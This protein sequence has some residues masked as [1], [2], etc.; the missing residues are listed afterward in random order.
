MPSM[1]RTLS[2]PAKGA[3]SP[4]T[5][6]TSH[7]RK[8]GRPRVAGGL[9]TVTALAPLVGL[10]V[11]T[12]LLL[13]VPD[14][15]H[16]AVARPHG[17]ARPVAA[18]DGRGL[19]LAEDTAPTS[20]MPFCRNSSFLIS[21]GLVET[22]M[23]T[24]A[25][26]PGLGKAYVP[27]IS[28]VVAIID[29]ANHART[30]SVD[31]S[32]HQDF[33]SAVLLESL[34]RLY[35][36]SG[37][38]GE[39]V[40]IQVD[41]PVPSVVASTSL[42]TALTPVPAK[43]FFF[44]A[45]LDP[46]T[47]TAYYGEVTGYVA[48]VHLPTLTVTRTA[49]L[50]GQP[51]LRSAALDASASYLFIGS[52]N[53]GSGA[54]V[55]ILHTANLTLAAPTL[56]FPSHSFVA[57]AANAVDNVVY[58]ASSYASSSVVIIDAAPPFAT[59]ILALPADDAPLL[60]A[61]YIPSAQTLLLG[62][63][64]AFGPGTSRV[65]ALAAG[66]GVA[67]TRTGAATMD[68][69]EVSLVAAVHDAAADAVYLPCRG[70]SRMLVLSLTPPNC[71]AIAE[72]GS[73]NSACGCGWCASSESCHT[74]DPNGPLDGATCPAAAWDYYD[75]ANCVATSSSCSHCATNPL[76]GWCAATQQCVRGSAS[77]PVVASYCPAPIDWDYGSCPACHT[78]GPSCSACVAD[79][80]CGWCPATAT[81]ERG[82]APDSYTSTCPSWSFAACRGPSC[83][84]AASCGACASADPHCG[85]CAS[86]T[87]CIEGNATTPYPIAASP[88][89]CPG[90]P[91]AWTGAVCSACSLH[92]NCSACGAD[93]LCGWCASSQS[94]VPGAASGPHA[95]PTCDAADWSYDTSACVDCAA[96]ASCSACTALTG[97]GWC[98]Q[99]A[100]CERGSDTTSYTSTC[101][102]ASGWARDSC[103]VCATASGSSCASC[104]SLAGCGWCAST[105]TCLA[106]DAAGAWPGQATCPVTHWDFAGAG[107]AGCREC[108]SRSGCATCQADRRCGFCYAD[109]L[110]KPSD[111]ATGSLIGSQS[112]GT[113]EAVFF[114]T[115]A[116]CPDLCTGPQTCAACAASDP[117]CGWCASS[118][119]CMPSYL[120]NSTC[121][122][123]DGACDRCTRH[124]A[125]CAACIAD[126]GC[127]LCDY[128][129]A[130][131]TCVPGSPT[132]PYDIASCP[133]GSLDGLP[134]WLHGT[135]SGDGLR[136]LCDIS[137]AA[138]AAGTQPS[139]AMCL[140]QAGCGWCP[141][142][143]TCHT[144]A[145]STCSRDV[146]TSACPG[147]SYYYV[148]ALA[149][150]L[151]L[152]LIAGCVFAWLY[153]RDVRPLEE[154]LYD[155][156]KAYD[157]ANVAA[158][159]PGGVDAARTHG[160]APPAPAKAGKSTAAAAA[161]NDSQ[162]DD[163]FE[164]VGIDRS[165]GDPDSSADAER[166]ERGLSVSAKRRKQ[167]Q[168]KVA[169]AVADASEHRD[170]SAS[171]ADLT[172]ASGPPPYARDVHLRPLPYAAFD[173]TAVPAP[174]EPKAVLLDDLANVLR[175]EE[176][177]L[178]SALARVVSVSEDGEE[179]A[180][181]LLTVL[182]AEGDAIAFVDAVVA[183]EVAVTEARQSNTLLRA[184]TMA[185]KV[186]KAFCGIEALEYVFAV[187]RPYLLH[188]LSQK[189]PHPLAPRTASDDATALLD[190][191][192]AVF[193]SVLE[194]EAG[195]PAPLRAVLTLLYD[196][197]SHSQ[198][199]HLSTRAVSS[200]LFLRLLS[201]ALCSPLA[202]GLIDIEADGL[203]PLSGDAQRNLVDVSKVLQA[204]A[205]QA[206]FGT[207]N[208]HLAGTNPW[209][210]AAIR[211]LEAFVARLCLDE[212]HADDRALLELDP[213]YGTPVVE[214]A[215]SA[216]EVEGALSALVRL[217]GK[218]E[219]ELRS[220]L[221]EAALR[222]GT[223]RRCK[224][225]G[226]SARGE[227]PFDHVQ[228]NI[229]EIFTHGA[230]P[231]AVAGIMAKDTYAVTSALVEVVKPDEGDD[232]AGALV[233]LALGHDGRDGGMRLVK[234]LAAREL[235][236]ATEPN[237]VLRG[238]HVAAKVAGLYAGIVGRAWRDAVVGPSLAVLDTLASVEDL[239]DA[240]GDLLERAFN[241]IDALPLELRSI[242][243][244]LNAV[245]GARFPKRATP[246][247][248]TVAKRMASVIVH[249][250]NDMRFGVGTPDDVVLNEFVARNVAVMQGFLMEASRISEA[251]ALAAAE[252]AADAAG[253]AWFDDAQISSAA[254]YIASRLHYYVDNA[255][256]CYV[257]HFY[258]FYDADDV[259][260]APDASPA[261]ASAAALAPA[262][263]DVETGSEWAV[264]AE[265]SRILR[266]WRLQA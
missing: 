238:F 75:C 158:G 37:T 229:V 114:E 162:D 66:P 127:G 87:S 202:Y 204:V 99:T 245:V 249:M 6:G 103:P 101:T 23:R 51:K 47:A 233:L 188:A 13:L 159:L 216:E 155:P 68:T 148:L 224:S 262:T 92:T 244:H 69:D 31:T 96:A 45:V 203:P 226:T 125:D 118:S 54:V 250:V 161:A 196:H 129:S 258:H 232:V 12:L 141:S 208:A 2:P 105:A 67:L 109:G 230:E 4:P 248:R 212:P 180:N 46:A 237:A 70:S 108:A 79:P 14:N 181:A 166:D 214:K 246:N 261:R 182:A 145:L 123:W 190:A 211:E 194:S 241:G 174:S 163:E 74:G 120:S 26:D 32:P 55:A 1:G 198:F 38:S 213:A 149:L 94:C 126:D 228:R 177:V 220:L 256:F 9:H 86:S 16:A 19:L 178:A 173:S 191:V 260:Y 59:S 137:S 187:L 243:D 78:L 90:D 263:D 193:A 11:I 185:S 219:T 136:D 151:L 60:S 165:D 29:T 231:H 179:A 183:D 15:T 175:H 134:V 44:A 3:S 34:H 206:L 22:D 265:L 25:L 95:A 172:L 200:V 8:T 223:S 72:C 107:G 176:H 121:K 146:V 133:V 84:A 199:A 21:P 61:V 132:G 122:V 257:F 48:S 205:N 10:V 24:L 80:K 82:A 63:D 222:P 153:V 239:V 195:F 62:T 117:R 91:S 104:T 27:F 192:D 197:V 227:R 144:P 160:I 142:S 131:S 41:D 157:A 115:D 189:A 35:L 42:R 119:T 56:N 40:V 53:A 97:C 186:L 225:L 156:A 242:A 135:C 112:C 89:S 247:A 169:A 254:A 39:L 33:L 113:S 234:V 49:L 140:A 207:R 88:S 18:D 130:A 106:G 5:A 116:T 128:D 76:C 102:A 217:C 154:Q 218:Y 98:A 20:S 215:P 266:E 73:C 64:I 251:Q 221:S 36:T 235:R 83:A 150:V 171:G 85:W 236:T 124:G 255:D 252:L 259:D 167:T 93:E 30:G 201:P 52:L 77:G 17:P 110:C 58:A 210:K 264:M 240:V 184:N 65:I 71:S 147:Y 7:R 43:A 111:S 143:R 57:L 28:P 139:C 138:A 209:V 164:L 253:E 100:T 170:D 50:P 168:G 152:L 81:C